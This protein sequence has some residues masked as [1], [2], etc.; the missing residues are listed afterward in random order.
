MINN[1]LY[2]GHKTFDTTNNTAATLAR[3]AASANKRKMENLEGDV[4]PESFAA[5]LKRAD[6]YETSG[7]KCGASDSI[8]VILRQM[9]EPT[10]TQRTVTRDVWHNG[11]HVSVTKDFMKGNLITI[12]G[13]ANPDWV[14]VDT[15]VGTVKIDLNDTTSLMKCL[16]M[17]SPED[18]TAIMKKIMEVKQAREAMRQ[19]DRMQDDLMKNEREKEEQGGDGEGTSIGEAVGVVSADE[20]GEERSSVTGVAMSGSK[21]VFA[22][23]GGQSKKFVG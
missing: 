11:A 20:L 23:G 14:Y 6:E 21:G 16:D 15:S 12:G 17:F 9:D 7:K 3:Q 8:G 22:V 4:D 10:T 1:D 5:K 2:M 13:S 18:V 19:I